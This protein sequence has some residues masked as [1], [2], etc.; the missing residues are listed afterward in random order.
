ML[1]VFQLL[2]LT[3]KMQFIF[4][5]IGCPFASH[6][7]LVRRVLRENDLAVQLALTNETGA[8]LINSSQ[9]Q[10]LSFD[11]A[12]KHGPEQRQGFQLEAQRH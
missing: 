9:S 11:L 6:S 3:N 5:G 8:S 12:E 7:G 2:P 10:M 4:G 1:G